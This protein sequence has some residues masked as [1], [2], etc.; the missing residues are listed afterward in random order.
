MAEYAVARIEE[1]D[2]IHYQECTLR[3][4]RHHFGIRAFVVNAWTPPKAGDRLMPE[5]REDDHGDDARAPLHDVCR[6]SDL[7]LSQS[8]ARQRLRVGVLR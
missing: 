4:V 7:H 1:L 5:H 6:I 2:E 3:P 8:S